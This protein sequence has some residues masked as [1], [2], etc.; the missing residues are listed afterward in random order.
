MKFMKK[1][2]FEM[3]AFK[4][5]KIIMISS[6]V[7]INPYIIRTD[8]IEEANLRQHDTGCTGIIDHTLLI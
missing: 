5:M 3:M 6:D 7:F 8:Y 2:F 1:T 4:D